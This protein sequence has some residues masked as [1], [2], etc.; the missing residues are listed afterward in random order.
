[1]DSKAEGRNI[2]DLVNEIVDS[3]NN[4][5][6]EQA[7]ASEDRWAKQTFGTTDLAARGYRSFWD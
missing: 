1:M 2:H 5:T 4:M 3:V 7:Q 6:A